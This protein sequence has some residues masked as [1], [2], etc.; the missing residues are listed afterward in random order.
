MSSRISASTISASSSYH[1]LPLITPRSIDNQNGK[2]T[3]EISRDRRTVTVSGKLIHTP[4]DKIIAY[5]AAA[6]VEFRSSVMGS[7]LPYMSKEQA[8]FNTPNQGIARCD[9]QSFRLSIDMPGSYYAGL[10]TVLIPPTLFLT[11]MIKGNNIVTHIPM[12]EPFAFRFNTYPMQYTAARTSPE[13]YKIS[14]EPM[15]RSQEAI[16]RASAYPSDNVMPDNFW[17][18]KPPV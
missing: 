10:G 14:P 12:D 11:Y 9:N 2:F 13:F 1:P 8:F 7:G 17:G 5:V 4:D 16:L 18:T 3:V 6:P 15:V